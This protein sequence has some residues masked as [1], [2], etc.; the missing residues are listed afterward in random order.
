[1]KKEKNTQKTNY[2]QNIQIRHQSGDYRPTDKIVFS[3][4]KLF[5]WYY[6]LSDCHDS[7][8]LTSQLC[9]LW[10]SSLE[11]STSSHSRLIFI[12]ILFPQPS[13]RPLNF[14]QAT[15][16]L[17]IDQHGVNSWRRP[18]LWGEGVRQREGISVNLLRWTRRN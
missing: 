11:R 17:W 18:R 9:C 13:L 3:L 7:R 16:T 10:S 12:I 8:I 14:G 2:L 6:G 4:C 5:P 15:A 1:M